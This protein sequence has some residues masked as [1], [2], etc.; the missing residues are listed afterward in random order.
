MTTDPKWIPFNNG[1]YR[2]CECCGVLFWADSS[3]VVFTDEKGEYASC[4]RCYGLDAPR[5]DN[6]REWQIKRPSSAQRRI[7]DKQ[8]DLFS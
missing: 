7:D 3:V 6:V 4:V 5:S 1:A 2:R 8:G